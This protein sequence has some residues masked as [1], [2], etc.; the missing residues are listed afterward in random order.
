MGNAEST[1][2]DDD[3][4]ELESAT[5]L[6]AR[7]I[8]QLYRRFQKLDKAQVG[9]ISESELMMIPEFASNPLC[10]RLVE[11]VSRHGGGGGQ[12]NF[13]QFLVALAVFSPFTAREA[14]EQFAFEIYDVDNDGFI[15][16]GD[17]CHILHDLV[18]SNI[19]DAEVS[20]IA[21]ITIEAA[22]V[23]DGDGKISR[24]EFPASMANCDL[25]LRMRVRL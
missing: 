17:L 3:V 7:Q 20:D 10:D 23:I 19:T 22:D 24:Q 6:S 9:V 16:R 18:G 25:G 12:I 21:R 1:L 14:K 11:V 5:G 15:S 8:R 4:S 2:E 13:R